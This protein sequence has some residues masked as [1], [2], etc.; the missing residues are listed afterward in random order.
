VA[1]QQAEW[2]AAEAA[3]EQAA[4]EQWLQEQAYWD[5][6][7]A[8]QMATPPQIVEDQW[9]LS[10]QGGGEDPYAALLQMEGYGGTY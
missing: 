9:G 7:A 8:E 10:I 2:A 4:Y 5:A 3:A 1:R 6:Y